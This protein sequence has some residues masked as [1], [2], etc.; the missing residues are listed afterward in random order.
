[1]KKETRSPQEILTGIKLGD[2]YSPTKFINFVWGRWPTDSES[3]VYTVI[4]TERTEG[5]NKTHTHVSTPLTNRAALEKI[6][7]LI[8]D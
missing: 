6:A 8:Q 7:S 4:M 5:P 1:M 2:T 3:G